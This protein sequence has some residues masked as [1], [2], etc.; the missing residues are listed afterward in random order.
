MA[1]AGTTSQRA[2][3]QGDAAFPARE[4]GGAGK[5][6]NPA[7]TKSRGCKSIPTANLHESTYTPEDEKRMKENESGRSYTEEQTPF[8]GQAQPFTKLN[9]KFI[10]AALQGDPCSLGQLSLSSPCPR[11]CR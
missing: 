1:A 4:Q 7:E 9:T 8:P 10:Q 11:C 2:S 6:R 5:G 3:A